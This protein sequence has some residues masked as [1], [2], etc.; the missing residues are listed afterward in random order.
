MRCDG[1]MSVH[2]V[3]AFEIVELGVMNI[4][5][6]VRAFLIHDLLNILADPFDVRRNGQNFYAGIDTAN[7]R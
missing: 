6:A 7:R 5:P 3:S 4:V 1:R 2:H